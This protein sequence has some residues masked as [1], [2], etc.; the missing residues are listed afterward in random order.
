MTVRDG[1]P[2]ALASAAEAAG[3]APSIHNTQPWHWRVHDGVADLFADPRRQLLASDPDR[4]LL[5]LSCGMALHHARIALA[6]EGV[7]V[8]VDR[9]PD[10]GNVDLLATVSIT[11]STPVT[12]AAMRLVQTAEIRHT[13]RRPLLDEPVPPTALAALHSTIATSPV[14]LDV[15]DRDQVIELAAAT[16]RSQSNEI[17]D[18]EVRAELQAW[19]TGEHPDGTGIPDANIPQRP[20]QTTVPSRDFGHAG[21]L[22][23]SSTHDSAASYA[24]LYGSNDDPR[25]WLEAGEAFSALWLTATELSVAV[26]PLSAAVETPAQRHALRRILS[27]VG[28]PYLAMRLGI[29]DPE[30]ASLPRTPRLAPSATVEV[31]PS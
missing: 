6:A 24:I 23:T 7:A 22:P 2:Q 18:D 4:R 30:Q 29:A 25:A 14:R 27:G 5:I 28:Y 16:D 21:T 13:D 15:L 19:T 12:P 10:P 9:I 17:H 1:H 11:G 31:V 20:L 8:E 3:A 26:L